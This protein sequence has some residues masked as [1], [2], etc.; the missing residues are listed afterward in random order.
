ME[1]YYWGNSLTPTQ[2]SGSDS[3]KLGVRK[4]GSVFCN[5]YHF[6][7]GHENVVREKSIMYSGG[8]LV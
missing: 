2:V 1:I 4:V 7:R 3:I 8:T 5:F 6:L